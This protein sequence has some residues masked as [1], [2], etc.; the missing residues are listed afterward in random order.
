MPACRPARWPRAG[1][2]G[3]G[4]T[5]PSVGG[6]IATATRE[7]RGSTSGQAEGESPLFPPPDQT[8]EQI[9]ETVL[10]LVHQPPRAQGLK[11]TRWSLNALRRTAPFSGLTTD[12]GVH[13]ALAHLGVTYKR[14]R[15][16]VH[17][18]DTH[19]QAKVDLL[20]SC[21]D[22]SRE[23]PERYPFL[24]LDELTYYRQPTVSWAYEQQGPS[25]ALARRSHHCNTAVRIGAGMDAISARVIYYQGR[26]VG[27]SELVELFQAI[28]QSYPQAERIYVALDNWP[29]HYHQDVLGALR[30]QDLPYPVYTPRNWP[31]QPRAK[32]AKL[33]LPIQLVQ[34]P[35][36]APWTNPIEK[37]WRWLYQ[38]VLHLHRMADD[39]EG[40]KREVAS[41]L[42]QFQTGSQDLLRYTGLCPP[43]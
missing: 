32:V 9:R 43:S 31:T 35:T 12:S 21:L 40:L 22:R 2:T 38:D 28:C 7:W 15:A 4:A 25:Q 34:L 23:D 19:Y 6:P 16:Y 10:D 8:K 14:G 18:P 3:I 41:F 24:Y 30:P 20:A 5:I 26:R 29:V 17:S 27:C 1:S 37:L 36:Y 33:N 42:G 11:Q 13:R 39:L